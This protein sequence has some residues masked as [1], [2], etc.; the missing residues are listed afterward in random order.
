MVLSKKGTD[1]AHVIELRPICLGDEEVDRGSQNHN[2]KDVDGFD[3]CFVDSE[4][5]VGGGGELSF[6]AMV[7]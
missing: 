2:V 4:D 5:S 3:Y 6:F 1:R 7:S